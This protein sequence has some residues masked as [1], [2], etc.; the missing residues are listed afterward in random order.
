MHGAAQDPK[1]KRG[2]FWLKSERGGRLGRKQETNKSIK[3]RKTKLI[4]N[5]ATLQ[6]LRAW[7]EMESCVEPPRWSL[8]TRDRECVKSK[9]TGSQ[10]KGK[11][12]PIF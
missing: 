12:P 5:I 8:A 1:A 9:Y 11:V 3:S 10:N 4:L 6:R 2:S 7:K